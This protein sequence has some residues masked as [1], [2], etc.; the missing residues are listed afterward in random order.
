VQLGRNSLRYSFL[1]EPTKQRLLADYEQ[2]VQSFAQNFQS[3][4]WAAFYDVRPVSYSFT[5]K[6]YRLCLQDR[7]ALVRAH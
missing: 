6:Q 3:K 7:S 5:C 4:G 1:D 2:R